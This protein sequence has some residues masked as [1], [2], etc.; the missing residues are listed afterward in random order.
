MR[1]YRL[2][3][4]LNH[5]H[6]DRLCLSVSTEMA[7][8]LVRDNRR[9]EEEMSVLQDRLAKAHEVLASYTQEKGSLEVKLSELDQLVSQLLVLNESL[10]SQLANKPLKSAKSPSASSATKKKVKKTTK[11]SSA[12]K[13]VSTAAKSVLANSL[14]T[15]NVEQLKAMHKMYAGMAKSLIRSESPRKK[16]SKSP[17]RGQL[18]D[19]GT[20]SGTKSHDTRMGRKKSSL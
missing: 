16:A 8:S 18:S 2:L 20:F 10:V 13:D 17:L 3:L 7:E 15:D 11:T 14:K 6:Y 4:H 12:V 5:H 19:S 1:A 9:H